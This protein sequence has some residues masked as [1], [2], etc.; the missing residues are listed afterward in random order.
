MEKLEEIIYLIDSQEKEKTNNLVFKYLRGWPLFLVFCM[1]GLAVGYFVYKNSPGK[2]QIT[3]RILVK[4]DQKELNSV[5]AF[6]NGSNRESGISSQKENKIQILKSYT[7]YRQALENLGWKYSWFQKKLMYNYDLYKYAPMELTIEENGKNSENLPLEIKPLGNDE[8]KVKAKG[9]SF[10]NGYEQEVNFE[11]NVK[12]GAPFKNDFFDFTINKLNAS[13]DEAYVLVFNNL[14]VLT[15]SYL[16]RTNIYSEQESSDVINIM[17]EG[18]SR[19]READFINELNNVLI[20]FGLKNKF[21]SS[22]NSVKFIDSQ[23][24]LLKNSLGKAEENISNYRKNNQAMDL[25]QEAQNVY[26]QLS[27]IEQEQYLTKLQIDFYKDLNSYIDDAKG[28]EDIVNPSVIGITDSNLS[29]LLKNLRDLYKRREVLSYSVQE[30]NPAYVLNEKEIKIARDGLEQTISNQQKSSELKLQSLNERH[31][32]IQQRLRRLPETEKQLIG[33]QRDF[34]LSNEFYTY[35]LQKKAEASISQASIAPEIQ[36]VDKAF[37]E[38]AKQTGPTLIINLAFGFLGG[39]FIPFI[40]IT[41]M[42]FFSNKIET[43]SEIERGSKV[44]VLDGIMKHMYKVYLPVVHHPRSGISESFRGLKTNITTLLENQ[45]SKVISV[46]SLIPG[47]GKSF[48]S[49]NLAAT[50]AKTNKKVL[51]IGADLHKPTLHMFID[52]PISQGLSNYLSNEK[53]IEEIV[54]ETS[55][56]NLF[57]IQTGEIKENPSD[58]MDSTRFEKLFEYARKNFDF[59]ILDNAP[60]LLV[61]DAILTSRFSDLVLFIIRINYS[62]KDEI[63]QIN[64]VVEFNKIENAAIVAN[65]VRESSYSYGYGNRKKYWKNGYGEYKSRLKIV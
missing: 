24:D 50:L 1:L 45:E 14:D 34:D 22:E 56:Q 47:E 53:T 30:K 29:E 32:S 13:S 20:D 41:L 17:I 36:I 33:V 37:V 16:N 10:I 43:I 54:A 35:M 51:L 57:F 64:K 60:L 4:G 5:L 31:R 49:S 40:I 9:K 38:A 21:E 65:G 19:Q 42:I 58:L 3:S 11:Q 48:I 52:T 18:Q 12:L 46:N 25:G 7:L 44:P 59:V 39:S 28:L 15:R 8:F 2:Y 61:P 55:I 27:S 62:H 6:N 23:L 63:R 26:N